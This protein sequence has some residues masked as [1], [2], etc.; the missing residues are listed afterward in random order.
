MCC[1]REGPGSDESAKE[2]ARDGELSLEREAS[3]VWA[4]LS[5]ALLTM[6]PTCC[7]TLVSVLALSQAREACLSQAG[8]PTTLCMNE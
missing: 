8:V 2:A 1:A 6:G 3:P 5:P 4:G 7:W